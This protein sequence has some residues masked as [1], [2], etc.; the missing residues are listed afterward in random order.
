MTTFVGLSSKAQR[1]SRLVVRRDTRN[2]EASQ[3]ARKE[4]FRTGASNLAVSQMCH[5]FE[6]PGGHRRSQADMT[7]TRIEYR[8]T[9]EEPKGHGRTRR[10]QGSGP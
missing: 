10:T 9:P 5:A 6:E 4:E 2:G 8:R 3:K 7:A 1:I